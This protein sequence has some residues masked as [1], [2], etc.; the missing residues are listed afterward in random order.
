V[1]VNNSTNTNITITFHLNSLMLLTIL[2]VPSICVINSETVN[3][4]L[5]L[6]KLELISLFS[7]QCG[8]TPWK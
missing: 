3:R 6:S 1:M 8:R 2:L 7:K 5:L 4:L